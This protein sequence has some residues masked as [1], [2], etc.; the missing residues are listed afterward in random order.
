[1]S[2]QPG[3]VPGRRCERAGF[4]TARGGLE[5]YTQRRARAERRTPARH[6]ARGFILSFCRPYCTYKIH[7]EPNAVVY[8]PRIRYA[9]TGSQVF[10][11]FRPL[12]CTPCLR[13][14]RGGVAGRARWWSQK[15]GG[16]AADC[17]AH[18]PTTPHH[19]ENQ[20]PV[21]WAGPG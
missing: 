13:G 9:Q 5:R 18:N 20:N 6:R 4:Q 16:G 14:G 12:G 8:V 1:M 2:M 21:P 3:I 17:W 7:V 10:P 11:S 19:P 15:E